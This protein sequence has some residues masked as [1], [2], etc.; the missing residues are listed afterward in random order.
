M[1]QQT[2]VA[3]QFGETASSYLSSSVHA[4]G[5][6][7]AALHAIA[8]SMQGP[9]VL[10]LGC[11]AGHAS[12]AVASA[13]QSVVAY[14]LSAQMLEVVAGASGERG[15]HNISTRQG[16]AGR[17]PFANASFDLVLTRFSA[18]HWPDVQGA[19]HEVRRVLR[20]GGRFVAI[21]IT[22][23]QAALCDTTLQAVELL[24]DGSHVRDYRLCEWEAKLKNAG[25]AHHVSSQWKLT[26]RFDEWVA[27]MRT[28]ALRV[29][30]IRSLFD[31]APDEARAYFNLQDDYSFD[32]DAAMFE[33]VCTGQEI[34]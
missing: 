30:A 9:R 6:D 7:L 13:A 34:S 27:R 5:A 20:A 28:P 11:G 21:D 3:Q 17:L 23:P 12:F 16:D 2:Y 14:D 19:L 33:A 22:A 25:F 29:Q 26:M 24:R 31:T 4:Q 10:D 32:I 18:H 15:L 1:K 8:Q